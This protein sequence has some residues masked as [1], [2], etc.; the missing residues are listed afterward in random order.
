MM[1]ADLTTVSSQR[2]AKPPKLIRDVR[3]DLDWVV[4][5][6]MEKDRARRYPTSSELA[7]DVERYLGGEAI[8][9]RP[10]SA[11]YKVRKLVAR[12][13]LLF[14]SLAIIFFLMSAALALTFR[15]LIVQK[16]AAESATRQVEVMRLES[17]GVWLIDQKNFAEAENEFKKALFLGGKPPD[18]LV[19]DVYVELLMKENKT[20]EAGACMAEFLSTNRLSEPQY[21]KLADLYANYLAPK[22]EWQAAA[23]YEAP[24]LKVLPDEPSVYHMLAPLL[25][26]T[27]NVPAYRQVCQQIIPRFSHTQDPFTADQMAK[28]CLILPSSGVDLKAVRALAEVAVTRGANFSS[29]PFF[30]CCAALAGYRQG[31]LEEAIKWAGAAAKTSLPYPKA[32]A[33]AVLAMAQ[34]ESGRTNEAQIALTDCDQII[35]DDLPKLSSGDLG[36][37]WRDWIIAHALRDEAEH[38]I[39]SEN[40]PGTNSPP[41]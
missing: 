28:D 7:M 41:K 27:H 29:Y 26:A 6:A 12:N 3:G 35:R 33:N 11:L 25:V 2:G 18:P 36:Q 16:R 10:P 17:S 38:L 39:E 1:A 13:K 9:A 21:L 20:D 24:L 5:K 8:L 37:D 19:L 23:D 15:L 4:M 34:F 22:G 14:G 32:E 30:Q 31:N 40:K